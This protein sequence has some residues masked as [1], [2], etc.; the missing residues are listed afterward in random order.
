RAGSA[1]GEG[2]AALTGEAA[3]QRLALL[4]YTR[5]AE[6]SALID[7]LLA[8]RRVVA[9]EKSRQAIEHL[10]AGAL[11]PIVQAARAAMPPLP[12][13]EL[14]ARFVRLLDVVAGR[15]TYL[16]L[17]AQYPHAFARVLRLLAA[18]RWATDYL[19]RHPILLD[20][21]L[22]DRLT[23]LTNDTPVDW[24]AWRAEVDHHLVD[25]VDD[26]ERAMNVT[27]DAHHAQVFRLLLA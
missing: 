2:G 21:L 15:T 7:T 16:A 20:E 19:V 1:A 27:R 4:G 24:T 18:S 8:S 23:S 6:S 5:P 17:L 9:S 11:D 13:D 26:A 25:L 3:A 12:A 14:L 22:D 10:L